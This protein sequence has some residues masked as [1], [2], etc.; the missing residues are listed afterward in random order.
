MDGGNTGGM[1][2]GV[3]V[4]SGWRNANCGERSGQDIVSAGRSSDLSN[5]GQDCL[6]STWRLLRNGTLEEVI[7]A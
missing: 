1:A 7:A 4:W 2:V 5:R 3:V 6:F